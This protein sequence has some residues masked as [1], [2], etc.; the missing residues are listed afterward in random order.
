MIIPKN[1]IEFFVGILIT[2]F[3]TITAISFVI[4]FNGLNL[5]GPFYTSPLIIFSMLIFLYPAFGSFMIAGSDPRMIPLGLRVG[6]LLALLLVAGIGFFI[7]KGVG[8]VMKG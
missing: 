2:V 1:W 7:L 3:A 5:K 8:S 4:F 6:Y